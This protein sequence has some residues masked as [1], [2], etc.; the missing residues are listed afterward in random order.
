MA[1]H[2]V[3]QYA[4]GSE[5]NKPLQYRK[6]RWLSPAIR[7]E[8]SSEG[9]TTGRKGFAYP[10]IQLYMGSDSFHYGD[11]RYLQTQWGDATGEAI[12]PWLP[13]RMTGNNGKLPWQRLN[14]MPMVR[15]RR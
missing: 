9:S 12:V 4:T 10:M 7:S 1:S 2:V 11:V 14:M 6:G 5:I 8:I 15:S 3:R 13:N